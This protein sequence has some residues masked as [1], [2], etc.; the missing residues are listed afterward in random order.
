MYWVNTNEGRCGMCK[1][2]RHR[3]ERRL[4]TSKWSPKAAAHPDS[5]AH[6]QDV[7]VTVWILLIQRGGRG[8]RIERTERWYIDEYTYSTHCIII[9]GNSCLNIQYVLNISLPELLKRRTWTCWERQH[10]YWRCGQTGP[11][12]TWSTVHPK[13]F[14]SSVC[15]TIPTTRGEMHLMVEL[16][17][18]GR[19]SVEAILH[20]YLDYIVLWC[21]IVLIDAAIIVNTDE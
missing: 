5:T 20:I 14:Y 13:T 7:G 9:T 1:R 16:N 15:S 4:C 21:I 18:K 3:E 11:E 12:R 10:R 2:E 6:C 19:G 17:E 8:G